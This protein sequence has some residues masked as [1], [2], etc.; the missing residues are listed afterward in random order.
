MHILGPVIQLL[1]NSS[2]RQTDKYIYKDIHLMCVGGVG[3]N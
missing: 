2:K 1:D 3:N